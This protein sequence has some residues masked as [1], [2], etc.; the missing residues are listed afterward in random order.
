MT[1]V[2]LILTGDAEF[3]AL[4]AALRR[5]FPTLDFVRHASPPGQ[6]MDGVT[7]NR[8]RGD[9]PV[10]SRETRDG[11]AMLSPL[12]KLVD[13]M[14]LGVHP[15]RNGVPYDHAVVV[16][17]LEIDNAD[18]PERVVA[19]VRA[20][21]PARIDAQWPSQALRDRVR[22]EVRER[23]SFH[24]LCPML[25]SYFFCEDAALDRAGRVAGRESLVDGRRIEA[26]AV[27]DAA[28]AAVPV[29]DGATKRAMKA[30][31]RRSPERRARHPKKY[32][33]Y[34]CDDALDGATRYDEAT[35]G[36]RALEALDWAAALAQ[37]RDVR[38][39]RSLFADLARV[40]APA[41]G[42]PTPAD[43]A[44]APSTARFAARD[45]VL[46]NV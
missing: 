32:L 39:L 44:C 29:P 36:A 23:C 4:H 13:Q 31:W 5:A 2:A 34:L 7:S 25:E 9:E 42:V 37:E 19:H 27:D 26:F 41:P 11:L 20:A 28:Y 45:R 18:Q 8:L 1:T 46:R 10:L 14:I 35:T 33:Q 22:A 24:L 21:V 12:A 17:D 3:A 38:F 40:A 43:D 6:P 16:D 15:G 30:D